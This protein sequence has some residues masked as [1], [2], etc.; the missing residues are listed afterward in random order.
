MQSVRRGSMVNSR[1]RHSATQL[2]RFVSQPAALTQ[3]AQPLAGCAAAKPDDMHPAST[4]I[5]TRTHQ[6]IS[7]AARQGFPRDADY[8]RT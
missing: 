4:T 6:A 3:A 7:V 1:A 2:S 8:G 5:R